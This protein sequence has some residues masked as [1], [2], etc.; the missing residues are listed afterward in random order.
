MSWLLQVLEDELQGINSLVEK[1]YFRK[2]KQCRSR[3]IRTERGCERS[4]LTG[5]LYSERA[6]ANIRLVCTYFLLLD[7]RLLVFERWIIWAYKYLLDPD[8]V[9]KS[10]LA[11]D[12]D[13]KLPPPPPSEN[14]A[15]T[16]SK[17]PSQTFLRY[18]SLDKNPTSIYDRT[19]AWKQKGE[20][21]M[22]KKRQQAKISGLSE[23]TFRPVVNNQTATIKKPTGKEVPVQTSV[24]SLHWC[25][26][27]DPPVSYSLASFPKASQAMW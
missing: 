13:D 20:A 11:V 3:L 14:V 1:I 19:L 23:C 12:G 10:C 15:P 5:R 4:L 6:Q 26:S 17:E 2:N 27:S 21:K 9:T 25:F 16:E 8:G 18:D 22:Q 24:Y 7:A